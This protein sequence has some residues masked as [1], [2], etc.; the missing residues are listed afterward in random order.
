[1]KSLKQISEELVNK[2]EC[3]DPYISHGGHWIHYS[4]LSGF[5]NDK[6]YDVCFRETIDSKTIEIVF[7]TRNP[8]EILELIKQIDSE[9]QVTY[10]RASYEE[11]TE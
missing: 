4:S 7:T 8:N 5:Y 9:S 10:T 3:P 1:M 11:I 6:Y 2:L